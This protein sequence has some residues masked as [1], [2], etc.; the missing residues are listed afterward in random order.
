MNKNIDPDSR[1]QIQKFKRKK[2]K[3]KKENPKTF[4]TNFKSFARVSPSFILLYSLSFLKEIMA[5]GGGGE[6]DGFD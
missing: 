1:T 5:K 4:W 6:R 3:K 2:E